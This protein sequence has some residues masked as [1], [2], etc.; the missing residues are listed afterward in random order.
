MSTVATTHY[1]GRCLTT[2]QS[3]PEA[4]PNLACGTT[5][6]D[7]GWGNV[8]QA[9]D[10]LD[11]HYRVERPLAVGGAG[12]TY[13]AREEDEAGQ[14]VGPRVAVKVLYVDR[15]SGGFL[16]RLSIEAQILQDL[17][18]DHI[19]RLRGFVQRAGREP[20]LVTVFEEG[21]SLAE[22][23][24]RSGPLAP[25]V[26]A[27]ILRQVLLALDVAHQ[28]GVVHRDLKPDNVL[29]SEPTRAGE[30]PH[31]RVADFGIAKVA[32]GADHLTRVGGFVG[33][34]EYAAPE[35]FE[36]K[37]PSPATDV[38]AAGG[39][40]Q[41]LLTARPP[42]HFT[43]RRDLDATY[44]ELVRQLPPRVDRRS[45]RGSADELDAL[46][47]VLSHTLV[48][49]PQ[50]RWTVSRILQELQR[51]I[52]PSGP[53]RVSLEI[54]HPPTP[55]RFGEELSVPSRDRP[56]PPPPT[57]G[58]ETMADVAAFADDPTDPGKVPPPLPSRL[59]V[60]TAPPP[61]PPGVRRPSATPVPLPHR[62]DPPH[63]SPPA[64]EPKPM[65]MPVPV[66]VPL[67]EPTPPPIP[68]QPPAPEATA[69]PHPALTP[70]LPAAAVWFDEPE[71][72]A[73]EDLAPALDTLEVHADEEA[74]SRTG[75]LAGCMG[76]SLL[77]AIF[78]VLATFALVVVVGGF[79]AWSSGWFEPAGTT[80]A[81]VA[82]A[83]VPAAPVAAGMQAAPRDPE[84]VARFNRAPVLPEA[85][86]VEVQRAARSVTTAI[87]RRCGEGPQVVSD[88]L[89]D[90][91]GT[92]VFAMVDA[93]ESRLGRADPACVEAA[94]LHVRVPA[95][96]S[97]EGKA[98]V[99]LRLR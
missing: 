48:A 76:V 32:G 66:L 47:Q 25:G 17:A 45:F 43:S 21:G 67:A 24:E 96:V 41:Y 83:P 10:L 33:T 62:M 1:C 5:Q 26:S 28:R 42:F 2:F 71:D 69:T 54:T 85:D 58:S 29:L 72:V 79:I 68:V 39:L 55:E 61:L 7:V 16:R 15:A 89:V 8:L 23:V 12:I 78:A 31:V 6:P 20:Y 4:C 51:L 36:G 59:P 64:P 57:T 86:I 65:P 70:E 93:E 73:P 27:A 53:G 49:D 19:V 44:E 75:L 97:R 81:P 37:P 14:L 99:S 74:P 91:T 80:A 50:A 40:L 84:L 52:G 35:Q 56:P 82:A 9:G 92:V 98:T 46:D 22:H 18:H 13:L 3:E 30:V 94:L 11:R 60:P 38:Y 95:G 77:G 88:V 34:P 90:K 63:E 87:T